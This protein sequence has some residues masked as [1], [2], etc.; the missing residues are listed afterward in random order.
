MAYHLL[1]EEGVPLRLGEE[2][3]RELRPRLPADKRREQRSDVLLRQPRELDPIEQCLAPELSEGHRQRMRAR[4]LG[5]AVRREDQ[6]RERVCCTNK[7]TEEEKRPLIR[8][9]QVVEHEQR[10]SRSCDARE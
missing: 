1:E 2:R 10:G 3:P 7:V 4:H 6:E 9:V 8:P 5:V